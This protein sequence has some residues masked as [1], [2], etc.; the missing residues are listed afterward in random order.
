MAIRAAL[1]IIA[2]AFAL[3]V[4]RLVDAGTW[5]ELGPALGG[6]LDGI[7]AD[8]SNANVLVV[9]SPGGGVWRTQQGG[10]DWQPAQ[11]FGL[12]DY[13][14]FHLEWDRIRPGR[15]LAVTWSDLYASTDLG[16][17]WTNLT[18][19]GGFPAPLM[20]LEHATDP[21]PFAQLK[22]SDSDSV[23]LWSKPCQGLYYSYDGT[24]F[25][26]HW[27]FSGGSSNPDND[28]L[29]APLRARRVSMLSRLGSN[30]TVPGRPR[31]AASR[32][33]SVA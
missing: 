14:V 3:V 2:A 32:S 22:L 16:D 28:R 13:S 9:A 19:F 29:A 24:A 15:L 17:D 5:T 31:G 8:P 33:I 26:Q 10:G 12:A 1:R 11:N 21:K 20:P 25:T 6:R 23:I 27:P 4:P 30:S 18:G 7:V